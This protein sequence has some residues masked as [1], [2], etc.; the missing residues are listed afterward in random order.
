MAEK[1]ELEV[2]PP[3]A[4]ALA[5]VVWRFIVDFISIGMALFGAWIAS[6]IA[7]YLNGPIWLVAVAGAFM[8]LILPLGFELWHRVDRERYGETDADHPW[9]GHRIL[10][11]A[12]LVNIAFLVALLFLYPRGA[13]TAVTARGDWIIESSPSALAEWARKSLFALVDKADFLFA[14]SDDPYARFDESEKVDPRYVGWRRDPLP[15]RDSKQPSKPSARPTPEPEPKKKPSKPREREV[16][17]RS[18]GEPKP[19]VRTPPATKPREPERPPESRAPAVP[20]PPSVPEAPRTSKP[21]PQE[22][23]P[24]TPSIRPIPAKPSSEEVA[25]DEE[26][27]VPLIRITGDEEPEIS[28][29]EA[30]R[31]ADAKPRAPAERPAPIAR[32]R[33][34]VRWLADPRPSALVQSMPA[35]AEKT[36]Q[37]V[38]RFIAEHEPDPFER[39][40]A[41]HDYIAIR[42]R[43]IVT[44]NLAD[45]PPSEPERVFEDRA[46]V[47]AGYSRLFQAMVE[48]I[49]GRALYLSGDARFSDGSVPGTSHAWNA[50]EILGQ[51]YLVD[52]TWDAGYVD[53][54]RF[55]VSYRTD[56]LLTP[57]DIF[58]M[59][60]FP[61]D[62][63]WQ[64]LD[65]PITRGEFTRQPLLLPRFFAYG[66]DLTEPTRS[67]TTVSG[68]LRVVIE[69]PREHS[70]LIAFQA[71]GRSGEPTRCTQNDE[72]KRAI[73]HCYFPG[74]G[75]YSVQAFAAYRGQSRHEQVGRFEIQSR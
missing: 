2:E 15:P 42:I 4:V 47:C 65:E 14:R 46:A 61:R 66:F 8:G 10:R 1:E 11:N 12:L 5:R 49:G 32:P 20:E 53:R 6:S 26:H 52:T 54:G 9:V 13:Y 68:A 24:P 71:P 59:T 16:G 51:W 29:P 48:T 7:A 70:V 69:N 60:H 55:V 27:G 31:S 25:V 50:V 38:A 39:V 62:S 21:A 40:K 18:V 19:K 37:D 73:S 34:Y 33:A 58:G 35:S 74:P 41:I 3:V 43:Y 17:E 64:L 63:R 56:Y 44:D 22:P 36:H 57:P 28:E 23:P 75:T 45:L 67:Q 72:D 30:A